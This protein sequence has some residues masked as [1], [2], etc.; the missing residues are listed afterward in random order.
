VCA[1]PAAT[2]AKRVSGPTG[3]GLF[4]VV[5]F[6]SWPELLSPQHNTAPVEEWAH[7]WDPPAAIAETPE[8][9]PATPT[10]TELF[11]VVP[12]P[13]WPEVFNPQQSTPPTA[14]R[15]HE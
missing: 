3:V 15:A 12:F 6:P 7:V 1:P 4:V 11:S 13:S 2:A 9:N 10:G 14:V 5:P 8:P